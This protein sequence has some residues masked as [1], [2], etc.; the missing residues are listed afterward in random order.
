MYAMSE[1]TSTTV[2][3]YHGNQQYGAISYVNYIY[4]CEGRQI[5]QGG[6]S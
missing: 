1:L 6:C 4:E 3:I 5:Y 2:Q